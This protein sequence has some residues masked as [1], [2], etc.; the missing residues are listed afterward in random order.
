VRDIAIGTGF[1]DCGPGPE[2]PEDLE[3]AAD[4]D[5]TQGAFGEAICS[6]TN[7]HPQLEFFR[8]YTG[9]LIGWMDTFSHSGFADV[10]GG[11]GRVST[12][13]NTFTPSLHGLPDLDLDAL[14]GIA[15]G[16]FPAEDVGERLD[17]LNFPLTRRCPN[18]QERPLGAIDP[19]DDSVPFT[20]G[21][22][23]TDGSLGQCDPT[24]LHAGP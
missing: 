8:A 19:G 9:E 14:L 4:G 7:G 10:L 16:A 22:H 12:T 20:D 11:V 13:F 24:Q 6:L 2:N 5:F 18:A 3:V 23:L 17:G 15:T 1:P 21:G